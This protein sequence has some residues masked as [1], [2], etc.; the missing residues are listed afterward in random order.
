LFAAVYYWFEFF[1]G[2]KVR[3]DLGRIHFWLTFVG[4]ILHSSQCI[5]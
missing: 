3:E 4:V 1:S 2:V 5:S